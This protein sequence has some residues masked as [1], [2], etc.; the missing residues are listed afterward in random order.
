MR[1]DRPMYGYFFIR[2]KRCDDEIESFEQGLTDD[3]EGG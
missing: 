1:D 3:K 2:G